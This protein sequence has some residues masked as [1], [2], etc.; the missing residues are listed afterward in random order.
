MRGGTARGSRCG[1]ALQEVRD[2]ERLGRGLFLFD[3][4]WGIRRIISIH[5]PE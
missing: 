5:G 1:V 2:G 3:A 4:D